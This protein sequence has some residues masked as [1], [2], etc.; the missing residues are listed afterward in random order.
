MSIT[1]M[2]GTEDLASI[3][4]YGKYWSACTKALQWCRKTIVMVTTDGLH[5]LVK[6]QRLEPQGSTI[7]LQLKLSGR[8][9]VVCS[10]FGCC[11][12]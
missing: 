5:Q 3:H 6:L 8:A 1:C 2:P 4:V 9:H 11:S 12:R 7:S 10:V